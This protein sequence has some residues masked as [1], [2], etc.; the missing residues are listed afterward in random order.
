MSMCIYNKINDSGVF[1]VSYRPNYFR[2]MALPFAGPANS[3]KPRCVHCFY[4]VLVDA[5]YVQRG[6]T[7]RAGWFPPQS[8]PPDWFYTFR[9][10]L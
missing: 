7:F 6:R 3:L 2:W 1:N 5:G 9:E 8:D 10:D 4:A